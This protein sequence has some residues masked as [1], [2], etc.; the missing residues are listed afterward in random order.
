MF[1]TVY[2][3]MVGEGGVY[4]YEALVRLRDSKANLV[5]FLATLINKPLF[6][7]ENILRI[8]TENK[9]N[10][11]LLFIN[12]HAESLICQEFVER[13]AKLKPFFHRMV[14]EVMETSCDSPE[15]LCNNVRRLRE[16]G[17][18][19]AIDD[20]GASFSNLSRLSELETEYV[21]L[22]RTLLTKVSHDF[23]SFSV[24]IKICQLI[25]F[26]RPDTRIVVEGIE[27][28]T[29]HAL[30]NAIENYIN[31]SVIRQGY[32]YAKPHQ[33]FVLPAETLLPE[34]S[35]QKE[36]SR[37]INQKL[38]LIKDAYE[39][40][41]GA[42]NEEAFKSDMAFYASLESIGMIGLSKSLELSKQIIVL[43]NSD[44]DMIYHN[45]KSRDLMGLEET[46]LSRPELMQR[47]PEFG[48]CLEN[49]TQF[50]QSHQ[51]LSVCEELIYDKT[52]IVN[53]YLI[54]RD[55]YAPNIL[56][57]I[58]EKDKALVDRFDEMTGLLLRHDYS[59]Y[60]DIS[61][62]AFMDINGLKE[63]NDSQGYEAGDRLIIE[64]GELL[65]QSF[66][67][68][69]LLIRHGGDEFMILCRDTLADELNLKLANLAQRHSVGGLS[70]SWGV[71]NR[72]Q[73]ISHD[74]ALASERMKRRKREEKYVV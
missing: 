28:W 68:T 55:D 14:I 19:F 43:K 9:N 73:D 49:D 7:Y 65:K 64:M 58:V 51:E 52:F 56:S 30:V 54:E 15:L 29:Q 63:V 46:S 62:L 17:L 71:A 38:T 45:K 26:N 70:F 13:V 47:F 53:R 74:I 8:L 18:S 25:L 72:S 34:F 40:F 12:V 44:G 50:L 67:Q 16:L 35:V 48:L 69:D 21:K 60:R 22:D 59:A 33:D 2:Q 20:F 66:R 6:D 57:F 27:T 32:F 39:S 61:C 42:G 23:F 1:Y 10:E 41:L 31:H 3:P 37:H 36:Q 4:A 24:L 11:M 5:N